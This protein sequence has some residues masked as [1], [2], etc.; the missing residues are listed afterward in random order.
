MHRR[1]SLLEYAKGYLQTRETVTG[2]GRNPG[3]DFRGERR[4]NET[5]VSPSDPEAKLYRKANAHPAK[6]YFMGH[7]RRWERDDVDRLRSLSLDGC[8]APLLQRAR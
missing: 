3:V 8:R 6:L 1:G 5:H 7:V 2:P 4:T